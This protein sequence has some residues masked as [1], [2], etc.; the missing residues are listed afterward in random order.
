[1]RI[2]K[3]SPSS[4]LNRE[5]SEQGTCLQGMGM[6][7]QLSVALQFTNESLTNVQR[8]LAL[9]DMGAECFVV[10]VVFMGIQ[11]SSLEPQ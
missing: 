7:W 6:D 5:K 10:V 8:I 3:L 9:V 11:R 1:M 4:V 2:F